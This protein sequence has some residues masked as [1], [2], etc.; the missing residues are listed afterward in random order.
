MEIFPRNH[1]SVFL[2]FRKEGASANLPRH[3]LLLESDPL[4]TEAV[5]EAVCSPDSN[6]EIGERAI[7]MEVP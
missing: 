5:T 6:R 2:Q 1:Q 7:L 3:L 4:V